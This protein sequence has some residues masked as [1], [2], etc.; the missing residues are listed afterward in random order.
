MSPAKSAGM[1]AL[2]LTGALLLGK[3]MERWPNA[4]LLAVSTVTV[5]QRFRQQGETSAAHS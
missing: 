5:Y 3:A 1:T 4:T 2:A